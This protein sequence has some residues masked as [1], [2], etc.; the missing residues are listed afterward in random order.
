LKLG[1]SA[2]LKIAWS[3]QLPDETSHRLDLVNYERHQIR[4]QFATGF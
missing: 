2:S 4:A 3:A 1:K